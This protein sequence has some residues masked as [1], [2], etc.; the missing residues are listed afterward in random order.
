MFVLKQKYEGSVKMHCTNSSGSTIAA[1]PASGADEL[2]NIGEV[3]VNI[4]WVNRRGDSLF[5]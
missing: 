1:S 3:N 4:G 2:A 5:E